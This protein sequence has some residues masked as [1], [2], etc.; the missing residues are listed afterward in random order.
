MCEL[1]DGWMA[2][3]AWMQWRIA[4]W[5]LGASVQGPST[6]CGASIINV[7]I[8]YYWGP[9]RIF[10]LWACNTNSPVGSG[11]QRFV[12]VRSDAY[13]KIW[14]DAPNRPI[15]SCLLILILGLYDHF[16]VM[17]RLMPWG[18]SPV[19]PFLCRPLPEVYNALTC[20]CMDTC[21]NGWMDGLWMSFCWFDILQNDRAFLTVLRCPT[22]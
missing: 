1:I 7:L 17:L 12:N 20:N 4:I 2:L 15:Q 3:N 14:L 18:H 6:E 16:H 11:V 22:S 13:K 8:W 10:S 19:H 21:M 5:A 9:R